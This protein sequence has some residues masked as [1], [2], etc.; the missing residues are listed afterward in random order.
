MVGECERS[1]GRRVGGCGAKTTGGA[2]L[3]GCQ[4]SEH[5]RELPRVSG[6][7]SE[8]HLIWRDAMSILGRLHWPSFDRLLGLRDLNK[9]CVLPL[10]LQSIGPDRLLELQPN[11]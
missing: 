3:I 4:W 11:L 7:G 5:R 9:A 1:C 2:A 10:S 8:N 6:C